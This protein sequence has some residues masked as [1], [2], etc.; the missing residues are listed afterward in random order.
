MCRF[1]T[2]SF[3]YKDMDAGLILV[4]NRGSPA[5]ILNNLNCLFLITL[6]TVVWSGLLSGQL[7]L[8]LG[9]L[10]LPQCKYIEYLSC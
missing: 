4:H 9:D 10:G 3:P 1:I 7:S 2:G 5:N 6:P 8:G